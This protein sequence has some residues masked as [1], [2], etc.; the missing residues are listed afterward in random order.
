MPCHPQR[1]PDEAIAP[2]RIPSRTDTT[3]RAKI[4]Q[5]FSTGSAPVRRLSPGGTTGARSPSELDL[6]RSTNVPQ[7]SSC[8]NRVV[9]CVIRILAVLALGSIARVT[10]HAET[11]HVRI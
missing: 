8:S 7:S 3:D 4:A 9:L 1:L 6:G 2:A 10:T 5:C 11:H